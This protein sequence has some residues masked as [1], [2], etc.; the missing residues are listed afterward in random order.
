MQYQNQIN[1]YRMM[2]GNTG[3]LQQDVHI[4][5]E[6]PN[7]SDHNEVELALRNLVNDAA[8]WANRK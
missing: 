2:T 4:T 7:V 1:N 3:T 8:Q 6:F 5:A